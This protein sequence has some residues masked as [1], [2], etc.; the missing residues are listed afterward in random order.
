MKRKI[1]AM[2]IM[3]IVIVSIGCPTRESVLKYVDLYVQGRQTVAMLC[4]EESIPVDACEFLF[5]A[6]TELVKKYKIALAADAT[7]AE[8]KAA[9]EE[10]KAYIEQQENAILDSP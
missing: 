1:L 6:N 3:M 8:I 2:A 10:L 9:I 5:E 4:A 7:R